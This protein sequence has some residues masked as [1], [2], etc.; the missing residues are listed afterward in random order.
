M[1]TDWRLVNLGKRLF[2]KDAPFQSLRGAAYLTGLSVGFLR[3]GCKAGTVPHLKVG[4]E[5]RV[6]VPLLMQQL[7]AETRGEASG[8]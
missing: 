2:I 4:A 1:E 5:Y 7:E 3:N 6:N 8:S